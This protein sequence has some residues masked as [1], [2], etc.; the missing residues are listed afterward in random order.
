MNLP[1]L[2]YDYPEEKPKQLRYSSLYDAAS[3][4]SP[5]DMQVLIYCIDCTQCDFQ[6]ISSTKIT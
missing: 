6:K 2:N 3:S 5:N 1:R 4:N